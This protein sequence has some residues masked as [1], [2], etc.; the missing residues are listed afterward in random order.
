MT[1]LVR[2]VQMIGRLHRLFR[3]LA[4]RR[5]RRREVMISGLRPTWRK[6]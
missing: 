3:F 2:E 1:A 6:P 4:G 5:R